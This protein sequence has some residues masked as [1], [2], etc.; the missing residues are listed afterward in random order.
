MNSHKCY[1][2]K[3]GREALEVHME[4]VGCKNCSSK[5]MGCKKMQA[6]R[7]IQALCKHVVRGSSGAKAMMK[8][9]LAILELGC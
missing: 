3:A 4:I 9:C 1:L 7:N 6:K 8:F 5:A 2:N